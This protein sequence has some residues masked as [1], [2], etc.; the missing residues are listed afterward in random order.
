MRKKLLSYPTVGL[1]LFSLQ[2]CAVIA[3]A[4]AAVSTAATIV[5]TTVTV[6]G[7]AISAVL[8]DEKDKKESVPEK[9]K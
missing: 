8:P 1:V 9:S 2:G 5:K 3:V 7:A 4:D 6:A